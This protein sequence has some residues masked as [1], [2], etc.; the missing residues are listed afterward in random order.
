MIPPTIEDIVQATAD[1][2]GVETSYILQDTRKKE[3]IK[4]RHMAQYLCRRYTTETL[5]AISEK[6]A[7]RISHATSLH[8]FRKIEF[9]YERYNDTTY[10]A[11]GIIKRL[12]DR[13]F[14]VDKDIV[15]ATDVMW[16]DG[17]LKYKTA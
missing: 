10:L 7:G 6:I 5:S 12:K 15:R 4:L 13:G 11:N 2:Y 14:A 3:V 9:E 1:E 17:G 16:Y 8:A